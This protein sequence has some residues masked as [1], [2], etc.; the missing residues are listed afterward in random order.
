MAMKRPICLN[1][2][3]METCVA[4]AEPHVEQPRFR[5][6]YSIRRRGHGRAVM[7]WGK[8]KG[9]RVKNLP[10]DYLSY[11]TTFPGFSDERWKWLRD[12]IE[13]ELHARGLNA[14]FSGES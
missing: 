12:S 9:V 4:N 3:A 5:E 11:L 6:E 8:W 2:E 10:D 7:P 14:D 1:A 13:K